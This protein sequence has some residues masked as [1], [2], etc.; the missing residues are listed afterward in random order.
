MK[1]A[2][3]EIMIDNIRTRVTRWA[4]EIGED[5]GQHIHEYDYVVVPMK[6][7]QLKIVDEDGGVFIS[8]LTEGKSY[9]RDK[10]A[11]HNV[12]NHNDFPFSF[13]EIEFK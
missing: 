3:S 4:F 6:D 8:D 13:V 5:T 1:M 10:G 7:G 12:I 2:T 11:N 9:Y